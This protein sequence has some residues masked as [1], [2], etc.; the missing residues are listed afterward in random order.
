VAGLGPLAGAGG[1]RHGGR[2]GDVRGRVDPRDSP[3]Y[4]CLRST[5]RMRSFVRIASMECGVCVLFS[6]LVLRCV[7][8]SRY[9][10]V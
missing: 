7:C 10:R 9:S 1:G 4:L 2:G 8:L 5:E 6:R 3:S